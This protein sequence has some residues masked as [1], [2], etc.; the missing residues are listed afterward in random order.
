MEIVILISE[1]L[2]RFFEITFGDFLAHSMC[3]LKVNPCPFLLSESSL[4]RAK[5]PAASGIPYYL[6]LSPTTGSVMCDAVYIPILQVWKL[7]LN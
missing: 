1:L 5:Q 2:G 4:V 3:S 7:R 6:I